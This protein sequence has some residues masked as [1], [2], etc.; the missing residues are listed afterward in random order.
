MSRASAAP[1]PRK[2]PGGGRR[3]SGALETELS[4]ACGGTYGE[5]QFLKPQFLAPR[6]APRPVFYATLGA[7][8]RFAKI[9]F[10]A[11]ISRPQCAVLRIFDTAVPPWRRIGAVDSAQFARVCGLGGVRQFETTM[12]SSLLDYCMRA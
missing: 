7:C 3:L 2:S 9:L 6:N 12:N 4:Q 10:S 1:R 11:P 5:S 8:G